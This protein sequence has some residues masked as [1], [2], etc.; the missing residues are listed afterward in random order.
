MGNVE[1]MSMK[2]NIL[3][4]KWVIGTLRI[5]FRWTQDVKQGDNMK[6]STKIVIGAVVSSILA[7]AIGGAILA[8][9]ILGKIEKKD[10]PKGN[11]SL[12]ITE[13]K[14]VEK[15]KYKDKDII[16]IALFGKDG[17][18]E[19]TDSIMVLTIDKVNKKVKITSLLRDMYINL[20]GHG[21]WILNHAFMKGG[22]ELAIKT[23]NTN[24]DL[25]VQDYVTINMDGFIKLVDAVG[26]VDIKVEAEEIPHINGSAQAMAK[27]RNY[28][29]FKNITGTGIQRLNGPQ[30]MAYTR[31]RK[32]GR[33]FGRT[34]RQR[35]V[36]NYVFKELKGQ[37]IVKLSGAMSELLPFLETSLSNK[38]I[39]SLGTTLLG[40]DTNS[41]EQFRLPVNGAYKDEII[42]GMFVMTLDLETNKNKLHEF[43]YGVPKP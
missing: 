6:K 36:L 2:A 19:R 3:L 39:I 8:N 30:A 25:D 37:G 14:V 1:L 15:E 11:E 33:D 35:E 20:P 4:S 10:I 7:I 32:V 22:S 28:G 24:F 12:G 17:S 21:M 13:E 23:I 38:D 5:I 42:Q 31:I 34:A 9:N 41:I 27:E 40:F 26:G 16:N 29:T 43:I 18:D